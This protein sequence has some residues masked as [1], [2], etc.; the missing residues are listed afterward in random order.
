[1]KI[2]DYKIGDLVEISDSQYSFLQSVIKHQ[3]NMQV[4]IEEF[5][6]SREQ[7]DI[8][9]KDAVFKS[10]L[11]SHLT[12]LFRSRGLTSEYI[13]SYLLGTIT[14]NEKPTKEQ[15]GA[16]NASIRALG[17]GLG[18]GVTGKVSVSPEA[19]KIEWND[20]VDDGQDTNK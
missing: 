17:M 13:K 15:M 6:I 1:M 7:L 3:G 20:G 8:W 5:K 10:A 14:G 19:V 4:A 18:R 9:D 16:I 11:D 2:F 12:V